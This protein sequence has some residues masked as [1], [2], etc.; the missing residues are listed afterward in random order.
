MA[1][2]K[3]KCA[4]CEN[5]ATHSIQCKQHKRWQFLCLEKKCWDAYYTGVSEKGK[6]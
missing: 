6:A 3:R 4:Y 5:A 1:T 2:T